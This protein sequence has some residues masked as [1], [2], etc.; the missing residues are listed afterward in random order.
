MDLLY[1]ALLAALFASSLW[2]IRAFERIA[3]RTTERSR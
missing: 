3:P 1:L 2:M